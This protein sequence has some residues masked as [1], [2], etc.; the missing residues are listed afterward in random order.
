MRSQ[1]ATVIKSRDCPSCGAVNRIR[2]EFNVMAVESPCSGCGSM[3]RWKQKTPGSGGQL[4]TA[5]EEDGAE[6][7]PLDQYDGE[8]KL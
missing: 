6:L 2:F 7:V 8:G 4:H 3:V 5:F 1:Y